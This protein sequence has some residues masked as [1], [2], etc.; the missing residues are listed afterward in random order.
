MKNYLFLLPSVHLFLQGGEPTE[1]ALHHQ[2][3][4]LEGAKEIEVRREERG[5][6]SDHIWSMLIASVRSASSLF[7]QC[8][9]PLNLCAHSHNP[10]QWCCNEGPFLE[11]LIIHPFIML[12]RKPTH[13]QQCISYVHLWPFG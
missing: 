1:D 10:V 13:P 6:T 4:Y 11:N 7:I 8:R 12:G 5:L 2:V 9:S 3:F